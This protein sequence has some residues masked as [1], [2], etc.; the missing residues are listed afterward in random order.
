MSLG[1]DASTYNLSY[2]K[3]FLSKRVRSPFCLCEITL[4]LTDLVTIDIWI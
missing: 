4:P 1:S 3:A 2:V